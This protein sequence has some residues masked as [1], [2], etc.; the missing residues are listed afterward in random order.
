LDQKRPYDS[1]V[2]ENIFELL[3]DLE[4]TELTPSRGVPRQRYASI[5][6]P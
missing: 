5:K 6:G 2:R 4:K 1:L 3:E